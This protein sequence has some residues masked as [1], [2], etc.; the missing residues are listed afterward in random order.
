[1][2]IRRVRPQTGLRRSAFTLIELLLVLVI[3][4]ILA[5]IVVP[6]FAGRSE[7]AKIAAA[8][9]EISTLSS[10]LDPFEQDNGS[11]PTVDEGLSALRVAAGQCHQLAWP[12]SQSRCKQRPLGQPLRL[13]LPR[14]PEYHR[15]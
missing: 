15:L 9:Q 5:A 14:E 6:K 11:Y 8:K 3:L 13:S 7:Q 2:N 1:M 12:L 10:A 4:G